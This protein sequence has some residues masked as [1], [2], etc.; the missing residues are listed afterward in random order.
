MARTVQVRD[1]KAGDLFRLGGWRT[2]ITGVS[3]TANGYVDI[4]FS[5][6][7]S[8]KEVGSLLMDENDPFT[9]LWDWE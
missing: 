9:I 1:L 2:A 8:S 3:P 6:G 5:V 7:G 4:A